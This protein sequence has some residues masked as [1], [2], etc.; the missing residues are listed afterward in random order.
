MCPVA[1]GVQFGYLI[2][3]IKTRY[4]ENFDFLVAP[5]RGH[6]YKLYKYRCDSIT[7]S[8]FASR[9][10]NVWNSLPESVV[11]TSLSAFKRSITTVDFNQLLKPNSNQLNRA[12]VSVVIILVVLLMYIMFSIAFYLDVLSK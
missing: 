9:V 7:A 1:V 10:D 4:H 5:I 11:F 6:L 2:A 3:T 8:F 12:T